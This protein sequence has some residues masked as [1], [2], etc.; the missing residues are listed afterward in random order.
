MLQPTE[1][2]S[3]P[4]F[5]KFLSELIGKE[6]DVVPV[7]EKELKVFCVEPELTQSPAHLARIRIVGRGSGP[8]LIAR[9]MNK[10]QEAAVFE[11]QSRFGEF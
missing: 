9:F 4:E 1:P 7:L 10:L 11:E 2:C 6:L 3:G 5:L 8:P